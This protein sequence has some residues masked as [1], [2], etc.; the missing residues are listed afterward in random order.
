LVMDSLSG[1]FHVPSQHT[2]KRFMHSMLADLKRS[3]MA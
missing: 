2:T 3:C 1:L